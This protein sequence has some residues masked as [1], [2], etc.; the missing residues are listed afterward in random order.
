MSI[1]IGVLALQGAYQK[2]IDLLRTLGLTANTIRSPLELDNCDALIL[3][4]G[5]STTI[6]KL[7]QETGLFEAIGSFANS[8]AIMGVCAGMIL[9]ADEVEDKRVSPLRLI[10]FKAVRN[11]Y[12]RQ[13]NSFTTDIALRFDKEN[14]YHA[15]F[16]R[17][18]SITDTDSDI[19][20]LATHN[21]APVLIR[22]GSHVAM[23]FHPELTNDSRIHQSWLKNIT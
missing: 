18:P 10:P 8:N 17:A 9:M 15:H 14:P 13:V 22:S 20:I 11:V 19:E 2:H 7:L 3:P 21:D 4:G 12:G 1:N 23:S 6:S 16:I 5:E